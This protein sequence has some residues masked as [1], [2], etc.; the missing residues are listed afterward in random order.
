MQFLV[1]GG[2]GFIG[3]HLVELILEK[4][5]DVV[6]YDLKEP[7]WFTPNCKVVQG[8]VLKKEDLMEAAKGCDAIFDCSGVLGSAE[9]FEHIVK[10]FKVN[11]LGTI[12]VLDTA[13]ELD[14]PIIY[15]SLKNEWKNPYMI[16]KRAG[17]ELCEMYALYQGTKAVAIKGLNAYGPRQ[18][19]DPVRKMFPRFTMQL[20]KGEPITIFGDGKQIVDM[21]YVTDMAEIMWLAFEKQV[22]GT[23]FDAGTGR[24]RTV[25][26]V[27]KTLV[28]EI[29]GEIK[30]IPH[31]IGE[32]HQAIA[33]AD[34]SF[35]LQKLDYFPET[36]WSLGVSK[37]VKWYRA[38]HEGKL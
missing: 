20:L 29:G 25:V 30:H 37:T 35:V 34:P 38:M 6:I 10:T 27:A 18:H 11:A 19:W 13:K 7:E 31:R 5:H 4:G 17:T 12:N 2:S 22:W 28:T 14:I 26:D 9:T 3:G 36:P 32:P 16:S 23:V 1:T 24:P 21:I 33:L 8:D 15:L